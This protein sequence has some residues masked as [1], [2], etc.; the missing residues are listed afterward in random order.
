[1][2]ANLLR[3]LGSAAFRAELRSAAKE[4]LSK[5]GLSTSKKFFGELSQQQ[6]T[7]LSKQEFLDLAKNSAQKT[8]SQI[9]DEKLF[10][11]SNARKLAEISNKGIDY[12]EGQTR[13]FLENQSLRLL[14]Q[15][16][17]DALGRSGVDASGRR[18]VPKIRSK[19]YVKARGVASDTLEAALFPTRPAQA[20]GVYYVRGV[21]GEGTANALNSLLL[22]TPRAALATPRARAFIRTLQ[23]E[24]RYLRTVGQVKSASQLA[25]AIKKAEA[26]GRN[27]YGPQDPLLTSKIAGYISGRLTVPLAA[28][29][30]F[31]DKDE[32]K[33]NIEKF[34]NSIKPYAK[35]KIRVWVD[36]YTREDGTRVKGHYRQLEVAA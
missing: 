4:I 12:V 14:N 23:E 3:V 15:R 24:V 5:Y 6:L 19:T 16:Y 8:T 35:N 20:F 26:A 30:V 10:S 11:K 31:V 13:K 32:R 17:V 18:L 25:K 34:Q 7:T 36:S 1:M 33:K 9:V 27:L 28:N 29:Y 22:G 21:L 2:W